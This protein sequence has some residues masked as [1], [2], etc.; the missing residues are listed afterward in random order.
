M[1]M[2]RTLLLVVCVLCIA[3]A[4]W[5]WLGDD[6]SSGSHGAKL[7]VDATRAGVEAASGSPAPATGGEAVQL[8]DDAGRAAEHGSAARVMLDGKALHAGELTGFADDAVRGVG[9][10]SGFADDAARGLGAASGLADDAAR[11]GAHMFKLIGGGAVAGGAGLFGWLRRR[12]Q[13]SQLGHE[14]EIR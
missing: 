8:V 2:R 7:A 1:N 10:A 11:S 4:C 6:E 13:K 12:R 9:S 14:P 5:N 3:G